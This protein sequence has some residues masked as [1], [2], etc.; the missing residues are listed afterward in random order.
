MTQRV[1]SNRVVRLAWV[2]ERWVVVLV[3]TLLTL[4][5]CAGSRPLSTTEAAYPAGTN[6][7]LEVPV[8]IPARRSGAWLGPGP[9]ILPRRDQIV[10]RLEIDHY[11]EQV[12]TVQRDRFKVVGVAR[13]REGFTAVDPAQVPVAFTMHPGMAS[14]SGWILA[15]TY[16][17]LHSERQPEVQRL[18]CQQSR[19]D[20]GLGILTPDSLAPVLA[21]YFTVERQ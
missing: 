3:I 14:E 19:D 10:C 7:Q 8:T 9:I 5:G 13:D 21:G 18:K 12:F 11:R 15:N 6:L 16:I 1:R 20:F 4:S 2:G 17:Y